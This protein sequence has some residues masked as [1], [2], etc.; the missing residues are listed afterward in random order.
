VSATLHRRTLPSL[1]LRSRR[2]ID[3]TCIRRYGFVRSEFNASR[4]ESDVSMPAP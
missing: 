4:S 2:L 3:L 1:R